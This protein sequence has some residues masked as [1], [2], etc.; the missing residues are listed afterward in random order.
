MLLACLLNLLNLLNG[1]QPVAAA[2]FDMIAGFLGGD[3]P[4]QC[5][6]KMRPCKNA[7]KN[8]ARIPHPV[9]QYLAIH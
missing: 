5:F 4:A 7:T 8:G 1:S 2:T 6:N 3:S 9:S